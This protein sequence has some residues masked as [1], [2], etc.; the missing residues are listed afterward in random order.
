MRLIME[1]RIGAANN[2]QSKSL[3]KLF[4]FSGSMMIA[5]AGSGST[6]VDHTPHGARN[7]IDGLGV[8][9]VFLGLNIGHF[10]TQCPQSFGLD[11][12][13]L[14]E[15]ASGGQAAHRPSGLDWRQAHGALTNRDG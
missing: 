9:R 3:Q 7:D 4:D 14:L 10:E 13:R 2:S 1:S 6:L 11:Q 15:A 5:G 8:H 12:M